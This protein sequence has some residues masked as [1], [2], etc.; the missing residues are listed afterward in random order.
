[1]KERLARLWCAVF[2]HKDKIWTPV[3]HSWRFYCCECQRE[4]IVND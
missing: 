4:G 2:H 1:V 3:H